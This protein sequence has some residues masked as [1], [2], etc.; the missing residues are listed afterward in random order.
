MKFETSRVVVKTSEVHGA[1]MFSKKFIGEG[2]TII[3]YVGEIISHDEADIRGEET[4]ESSDNEKGAVYL[5]T[6]NKR[7]VIDGNVDYNFAKYMNHS[8]E[9][10]CDAIIQYGRI[11]LIAARDIEPGE[12]LFF[13]YSYEYDIHYQDHPCRCGT[14][15]C[16]GFIVNEE[17]RKKIRKEIRAKMAN[18]TSDSD[19]RV[20]K[21]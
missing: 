13:D 1:G 21:V 15:K 10:N 3:E 8:C 11:F 20:V 9:P 2:E 4:L 17:G 7:H 14:S 18:M 16:V 12:E 6:L 5:F 19:I